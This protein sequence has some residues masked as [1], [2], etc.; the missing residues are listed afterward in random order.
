MKRVQKRLKEVEEIADGLTMVQTYRKSSYF[1]VSC[2]V[3]NQ[4]SGGGFVGQMNLNS[5][6]EI[7]VGMKTL[8]WFNPALPGTLTEVDY[9]D[10]DLSR[11]VR[12]LR[13]SLNL[14]CRANNGTDVILEIWEATPVGDTNVTAI[15][16]WSACLADQSYDTQDLD[17]CTTN[18]SLVFPSDLPVLSK[19]W[20]FK[21]IRKGLLKVGQEW[22]YTMVNN[23]PVSY[24]IN[25][26]DNHALE[27]IKGYKPKVLVYRLHGC[28]GHDSSDTTLVTSSAGGIDCRQLKTYVY[29]YNGGMDS[30]FLYTEETMDTLGLLEVGDSGY[31]DDPTHS[32]YEV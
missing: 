10:G 2:V 32:R 4:A 5:C 25:L 29:E 11:R 23:E 20:K 16:A 18:N 28:I 7:E 24:D 31:P 26:F 14:T 6:T 15:N 19:F 30:Q 1:N 17:V 21:S 9:T 22:S 8:K 13:S 27:Y 12:I 3:G